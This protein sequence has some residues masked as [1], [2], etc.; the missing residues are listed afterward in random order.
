M[1]LTGGDD[2]CEM[3]REARAHWSLPGEQNPWGLSGTH[4]NLSLFPSNNELFCKPGTLCHLVKHIPGPGVRIAEGGN[5]AA[6]V[7]LWAWLWAYKP[8]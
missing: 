8:R 7:V 1:C 6:A 4:A 3:G 2:G 5:P